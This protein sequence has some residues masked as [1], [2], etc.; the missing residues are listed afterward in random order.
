MS[1]AWNAQTAAF[2]EASAKETPWI[3]IP[4]GA[5]AVRIMLPLLTSCSLSIRE[6][7]DGGTTAGSHK[8]DLDGNTLPKSGYTGG[9]ATLQ[10]IIW[11]AVDGGAHLKLVSDV[12]QTGIS[13]T[14]KFQRKW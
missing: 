3:R 8:A 5:V 1:G 14:I 4:E 13:A 11:F 12:A 7:F 6:S 9:S 10:D 2:S